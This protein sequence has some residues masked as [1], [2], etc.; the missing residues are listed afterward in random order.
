M[1]IQFGVW[2]LANIGKVGTN[3]QQQSGMIAGEEG[4]AIRRPANGRQWTAP[5]RLLLNMLRKLGKEI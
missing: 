2:A 1:I 4:M 5:V 3:G